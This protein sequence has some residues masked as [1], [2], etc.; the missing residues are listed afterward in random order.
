MKF[1]YSCLSNYLTPRSKRLQKKT[2]YRKGNNRGWFNHPSSETK[3]TA[4]S[5]I[6]GN[7]TSSIRHGITPWDT[8]IHKHIRTPLQY[9]LASH[10]SSALAHI[11]GFLWATKYNVMY[12][13][14]HMKLVS[15]LW[16]VWITQ[17]N[18]LSH[19]PSCLLSLSPPRRHTHAGTNMLP[20]NL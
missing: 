5:H 12:F 7:V 19:I 6:I 14:W 9:I 10:C 18:P 2:Q 8:L 16:V 15:L 20:N 3:D 11:N 13:P 1:S 17:T 4:L